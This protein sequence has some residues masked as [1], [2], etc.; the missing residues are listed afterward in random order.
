MSMRD[1]AFWQEQDL[2]EAIR[3]MPQW[4]ADQ[5]ERRALAELTAHSRN[6][7]THSPEQ[8]EQIAAAIQEWGFAN[9]VLVDEAGTILAGHGRVMAARK[10]GLT[11]VPVMVAR[12]WS[13]E[14]K[15][16][17]LIA[18][19]KLTLN[20]GWN[21][22]ML[23]AEFA[24]LETGGFSIGKLGFSHVELANMEERPPAVDY[25][26]EWQGMPEYVQDNAEAYRSLIVHFR[27]QED[28]DSFLRLTGNT[29]TEKSRWIWYP[30]MKAEVFADKRY[31]A[32]EAG[33]AE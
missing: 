8:I 23:K 13:E 28:L 2:K 27:T 24:E 1:G 3:N 10:L 4:P 15:R 33:A 7:R 32:E 12:G 17:Y 25:G 31:V 19:N 6:S 11:D 18:D 26:A 22:D 29:I 14:Q 5:V 21:T 16:A 20:G 9:P 30:E